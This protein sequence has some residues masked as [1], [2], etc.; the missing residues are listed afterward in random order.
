[1]ASTPA[2]R[3][4]PNFGT[5]IFANASTRLDEASHRLAC[6]ARGIFLSVRPDYGGLCDSQLA[7][8]RPLR[9][10]TTAEEVG[11]KAPTKNSWPGLCSNLRSWTKILHSENLLLLFEISVTH[12]DRARSCG[13]IIRT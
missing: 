4:K 1:M 3:A 9:N 13:Y 12:F 8:K 7:P 5:T 11:G 6:H 2:G 10:D